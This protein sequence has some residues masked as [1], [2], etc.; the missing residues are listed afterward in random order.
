M[1]PSRDNGNRKALCRMAQG[2]F[3]ELAA[4]MMGRRAL[5]LS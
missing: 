4:M 2:F 5:Y 1:S 3:Q